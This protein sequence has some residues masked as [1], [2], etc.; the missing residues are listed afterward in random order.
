MEC[1]A[2]DMVVYRAVDTAKA[3]KN[4]VFGIVG[5]RLHSS[6]LLVTGK[7]S[8]FMLMSSGHYTAITMNLVPRY[9]CRIGR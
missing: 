2:D 4:K 1:F 3:V 5:N 6:L 7:K 9:C 8:R